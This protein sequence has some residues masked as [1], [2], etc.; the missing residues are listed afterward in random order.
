M[1]KLL[2]ALAGLFVA[3]FCAAKD[4]NGAGVLRVATL[5]GPSS[6]P[7]AYLYDH[8]P[9]LPGA[10]ARF[11]VL[12]NAT[13]VLPKLITGEVSVGVLPPNAAAKVYTANNGAVVA[14]GVCG[15]GNLFLLTA[16]RSVRTLADLRG[17]TV[18]CAGQGATPEY[19]FRFVLRS[20]GIGADEVQLD[21]SLANADIAAALAAGRVQYALV[22]EPF[23]TVAQMKSR[24]IVRAIDIQEAYAA[25]TGGASYPMTVLVANAAYAV[26]HRDVVDAFIAAYQAAVAWTNAHPR[27]A[28]LL[29][30][31]H[32]LGLTAAVV[33]RSIPNAA[34]VWQPALAARADMDR[35]LRVYLATA[36]QAV[37]GALPSDGFYYSH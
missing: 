7:V 4:K 27:E 20:A 23:A 28:G 32:T 10:V 2:A 14:L 15:N 31:K 34:Y 19:V 5:N 29:V 12:A 37:G 3:A 25:A 8:A 30:Q 36:P 18:A 22:P 35:L 17:K 16:D 24:G 9:D 33:E 21:F 1:K 11:E 26:A 13:A 6:V